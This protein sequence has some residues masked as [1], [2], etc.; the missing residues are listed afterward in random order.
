MEIGELLG[1]HTPANVVCTAVNRKRN[2]VS[3]DG[4]SKHRQLRLFCDLHT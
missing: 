4:K 1:A 2:Q 3:K